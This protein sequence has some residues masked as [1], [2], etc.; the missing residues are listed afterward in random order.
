MM[1][2]HYS[3]ASE[4][5]RKVM[6]TAKELGLVDRIEL[7][8]DKK[9]LGQ[10]NPLL[11]R[12]ALITAEGFAIINSPVICEYLDTLGGG[13]LIPPSGMVRWKALTQEALADG[14]MEAITAIRVDRAFHDAPSRE[15]HDRQMLKIGQ[16]FDAL[17][18][19]A[20]T[21]DL[22]GPVTIGQITI[23]VACEYVDFAFAEYDWRAGH[24]HLQAW[25]ADFSRRPSMLATRPMQPPGRAS[26][27]APRG[28]RE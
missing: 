25:Q 3:P 8:E 1:R 18:G 21:D 5:V 26:A 27:L 17:D 7:I 10:H 24:P 4:Y 14:I 16:G 20:R 6:V 15:W 13:K 11:K 12:P 2:L 19:L 28:R 9:D 22:A 23:A